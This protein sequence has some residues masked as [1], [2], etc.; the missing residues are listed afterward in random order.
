MHF[1]KCRFPL[2]ARYPLAK[3]IQPAP[4][5]DLAGSWRLVYA[6]WALR[7]PCVTV[8]VLSLKS[9]ATDM[10]VWYYQYYYYYYYY[11]IY[12]YTYL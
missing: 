11:Y 3:L 10:R 5:K 12:I 8:S 6:K 9:M 7:T 2:R 1:L 4:N